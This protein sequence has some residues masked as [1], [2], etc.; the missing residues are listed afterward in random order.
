MRWSGYSWTARLVY[1][2]WRGYEFK[3]MP[4]PPGTRESHQ[5]S[6]PPAPRVITF[7]SPSPRR[8]KGP[9][10]IQRRAQKRRAYVQS[11]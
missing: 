9:S 2:W 11:L 4:P 1:S 3:N 10:T 5:V 6:P 7:E 8:A